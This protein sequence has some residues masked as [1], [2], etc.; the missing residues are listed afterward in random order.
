[1]ATPITCAV[2][3]PQ[4]NQK[5]MIRRHGETDFSRA[6]FTSGKFSVGLDQHLAPEQVLEWTPITFRPRKRK[7]IN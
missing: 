5:V 2:E 1:M 6:K 7:F 3:L 4:N